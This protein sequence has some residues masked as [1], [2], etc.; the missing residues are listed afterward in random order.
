MVTNKDLILRLVRISHENS[1]FRFFVKR[2]FFAGMFIYACV[3]VCTRAY[4]CYTDAPLV[5]SI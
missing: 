2:I 3:Y 5:N 1:A 4:P